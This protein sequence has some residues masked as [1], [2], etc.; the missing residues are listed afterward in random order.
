MK[1]KIIYILT[2]FLLLFS[3][4]NE[5]IISIILNTPQQVGSTIILT[6]EKTDI[7]GFE[8][9]MVMRSS[10]KQHYNVI[11]D[12]TNKSSDAYKIDITAFTDS[13]Y[14]LEA[15]TLYYKIMAVRNG[16]TATSQVICY[17]VENKIKLFSGD[18]KDM[19]YIS[20]TNQISVI[21]NDYSTDYQTRLNIFDLQTE[22]FLPNKAII[23][24]S[25][26]N[27]WYFWSKY[28]EKTEFYNFDGN[29]KIYVYNAATN[30][31]VASL[32]LSIWF[33]YSP[34]AANN[35]GQ[36]YIYDAHRLYIINR[37]TGTHTTYQTDKYVYSKYLYY[38]SNENK[39]YAIGE[40]G[41]HILSLNEQG[42]VVNEELHNFP[43]NIDIYSVLL[44]ENTSLILA[45][46]NNDVKIF[47]L[48]N[49]SLYSTDLQYYY[50]NRACMVENKIYVSYYYDN[51]I[52]QIST[53]DYKIT[54]N[55]SIRVSPISFFVVNDYLYYLGEYGYKTYIFDKIKI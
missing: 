17:K 6:W 49:K 41:Y 32:H 13:D 36:I 29:D 5:E 18:F 30:Q 34:F 2:I 47:D 52:C 46:F 9:Y 35:K 19:H 44:I 40:N 15:D 42:N 33:G 3:C 11:N 1:R 8:Y 16:K 39:L 7:K 24:L 45:H 10:D 27:C 31:K 22:N 23:D 54:K 14:P 12:I 43:A 37:T 50:Y 25:Y 55:Y 26:S 48:K 21:S 28:N 4:K 53:T 38:N 20:E 51:K